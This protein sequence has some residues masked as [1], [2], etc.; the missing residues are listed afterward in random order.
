MILATTTALEELLVQINDGEMRGEEVW[1]AWMRR[2][3]Q[4]REKGALKNGLT[5]RIFWK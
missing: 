5:K 1:G 2:K 3:C 4:E